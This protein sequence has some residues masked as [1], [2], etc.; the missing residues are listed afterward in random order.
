MAF[1]WSP[2]QALDT[3][4]ALLYFDGSSLPALNTVG[5][6]NFFY[7]GINCSYGE[8]VEGSPGEKELI[9]LVNEKLSITQQ[10]A[11]AAR[12]P[13]PCPGLITQPG[14]Q[15]KEADSAPLLCSGWDPPAVLHP[16]L[17]TPIREEHFGT[18]PTE[19]HK[20]AQMA[21]EPP[22]RKQADRVVFLHP[23]EEKAPRRPKS[24]FQYLK[25]IQDLWR[26][27]FHKGLEW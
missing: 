1:V 6:C 11:M 2:S 12:K 24:I 9:V 22:L 17:R 13:Q 23:G 10:C 3:Q 20:N 27:T 16:A 4:G 26:G 15:V 5:Q 8:W 7:T 19:G 18:S 14:Q 25:G 21:G